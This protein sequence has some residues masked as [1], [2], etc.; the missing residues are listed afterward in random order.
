VRAHLHGGVPTAEI[1]SLSRFWT[2]YPGLKER[3]F[4][5][6]Q[7]D[8]RYQ[9]FSPALTDRRAIQEVVKSDPGVAQA[10]ADFLATLESWWQKNLPLVEALAPTNGRKG[11]VYDLRRALLAD[12]SRT[13]ASQ[14]LLTEHQV[15]GAFAAYLDDLKADLKS[16]AAS[17]WG[18]ELIPEADILQSQF[19]EL[20]EDM[21]KKRLRLAELEALFSAAD[22]EDYEDSEDTGVLPGE[23]VKALKAELKEARG[24]AKLAKREKR[25]IAEYEARAKAAETKLER[26]KAL[27][28]EAKR[29]K[30]ELRATEKKKEDLVEA[31][32]GRIDSVQARR[33]MVNRFRRVLISL[34]ESYLQDHLLFLVIDLEKL[35]TK[36]FSPVKEIAEARDTSLLQLNYFLHEL[37]Y[38]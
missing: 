31:A 33:A 14:T 28:D 21:E 18:P 34:F 24:E 26:H 30:A 9:D 32:Q 8:P 19:P 38:V 7:G 29:I 4:I 35:F 15:R 27:E 1:E 2:N 10:H 22:E 25:D 37:G 3:C 13:F 23:Q 11:N 12:I 5:P 16:I 20:L 17:G 6:R 36:Y